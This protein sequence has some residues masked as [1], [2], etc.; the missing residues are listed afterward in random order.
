MLKIYAGRLQAAQQD[1]LALLELEPREPRSEEGLARFYK[2]VKVGHIWYGD[3]NVEKVEGTHIFSA[4]F[5]AYTFP[6]H[7]F[8][9]A[10]AQLVRDLRRKGNDLRN[11]MNN[12]FAEANHILMLEPGDERV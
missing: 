9:K 10:Q 4:D 11:R 5:E 7:E 3:F 1:V 12:I 8:E 2:I 6:P